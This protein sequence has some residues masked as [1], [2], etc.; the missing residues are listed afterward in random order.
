MRSV[1]LVAYTLLLSCMCNCHVDTYI[2]L[3]FDKPFVK[4][5][6]KTLWLIR[7]TL[8]TIKLF[9]LNLRHLWAYFLYTSSITSVPGMYLV[10]TSF[11]VM[12]GNG[13]VCSRFLDI[14]IIQ[15]LL[16]PQARYYVDT[17]RLHSVVVRECKAI[18]TYNIY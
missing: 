5:L 9:H 10:M 6:S 3:H 8:T 18:W 4:L 17:I 1:L 2:F 16:Q 14:N 15:S 11:L 12:F 7:S 13:P